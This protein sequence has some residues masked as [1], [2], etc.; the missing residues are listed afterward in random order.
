MK[1][2]RLGANVV[3]TLTDAEATF[4][5]KCLRIQA[6]RMR[7][8]APSESDIGLDMATGITDEL[9]PVTPIGSDR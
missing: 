6:I 8:I 3:L 1:V 9:T 5:A 2:Q 7:V 4:V